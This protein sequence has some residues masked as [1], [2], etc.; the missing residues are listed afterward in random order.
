MAEKSKSA[1]IKGGV[2]AFWVL[3][4]RRSDLKGGVPQF[5]RVENLN[6]DH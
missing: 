3:C 2:T 1:K 5:W 6:L 4:W